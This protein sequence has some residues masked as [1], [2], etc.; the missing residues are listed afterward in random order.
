MIQLNRTY[1]PHTPLLLFGTLLL[2]ND[3]GS[4]DKSNGGV[5]KDDVSD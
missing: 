2:V 4:K 3:K 5:L 1:R